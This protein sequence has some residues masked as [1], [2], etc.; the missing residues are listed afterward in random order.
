M[1]LKD[2]QGQI[3]TFSVDKEVQRFN[4]AKVGDKVSVDYYFGFNAEV[5]KPTAEEKQNPLVVMQATGR[6]GPDDAPA[7]SDTQ[8]I[9]AVV[10]IEGLDRAN[11]TITVKGPRGNITSR[12]WLTRP[13]LTT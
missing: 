1:T 6:A 4:E 5:R 12:A 3:G 11:Q 7:G 9:R 10:T 13:G 2:S 8:Q